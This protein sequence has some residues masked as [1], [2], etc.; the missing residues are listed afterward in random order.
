MVKSLVFLLALPLSITPH[1][2]VL[3]ETLHEL[4]KEA[5]FIGWGRVEAV[6]KTSGQ[7]Y[8]Y[9][10]V[11]VSFNSKAD[12]MKGTY[13]PTLKYQSEVFFSKQ[14]RHVGDFVLLFLDPPNNTSGVFGPVGVD[15]GEF[16]ISGDPKGDQATAENNDHNRLLWSHSQKSEGP[17]PL[18]LL[19]ASVRTFLSTASPH[20]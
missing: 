6:V 19:L 10:V 7:D 18:S 9:S 8:E 1:S 5:V 14:H 13:K 17:V 11:T 3:L 16:L 20:K 2:Q 15:R 12:V 4:T